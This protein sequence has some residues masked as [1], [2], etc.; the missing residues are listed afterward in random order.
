M[1]TNKSFEMIELNCN[2]VI[3]FKLT[4]MPKEEIP[5]KINGRTT[6]GWASIHCHQ[7]AVVLYLPNNKKIDD[8]C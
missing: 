8:T 4:H 5:G 7:L 2:A 1:E 3:S 6:F